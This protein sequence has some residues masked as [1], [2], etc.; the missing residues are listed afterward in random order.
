MKWSRCRF[1]ISPVAWRRELQSLLAPMTCLLLVSGASPLLAWHGEGHAAIAAL[2]LRWA[3]SGLPEVLQNGEAEIA[4]AAVEPDL[5]RHRLLPALSGREAPE[6]YL[7]WE[8]FGTRELPRERSEFEAA[9]YRGGIV[10]GAIGALPYAL[11]EGTERLALCLARWR[12]EPG[13]P[14]VAYQC[15]ML[16][17]WLAHFAGDLVQPLHTTVH[18]DGW[19]WPDGSSPRSG[20]HRAVDAV[21]EGRALDLRTLAPEPGTQP[22]TLAPPLDPPYPPRYPG[23]SSPTTLAP[24]PSTLAPPLPAL[25]PFADPWFGILEALRESH[26]LVDRVYELEADFRAAAQGAPWSPRVAAFACDRLRAGATLLG[27][28]YLTA[29]KL[30][31][32]VEL[33]DWWKPFG[34]KGPIGL[35]NP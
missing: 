21:F 5:W 33:P 6:H 27:R 24:E 11:L 30:S 15:Q 4:Q 10:R 7:D 34:G 32:S 19:A 13:A 16:A 14:G 22:S 8:L 20:I 26:A 31:H 9:H 18:H 23:T 2:A 25:E 12:A 1:G 29:V 35:S 28:L 17:G 3:G